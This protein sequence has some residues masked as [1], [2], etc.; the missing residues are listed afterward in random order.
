MGNQTVGE[1]EVKLRFHIGEGAVAPDQLQSW[2]YALHS[3]DSEKRMEAARI[4][5][6][7]APPSLEETLFGFVNEPEFRRYAALAFH[8]LNTARSI[9]KMA[10]LMQGPA[11]SEQL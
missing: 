8:R 4:L 1:A 6:S 3:T 10:E 11:T 9:E 7:L 5:A 2:L